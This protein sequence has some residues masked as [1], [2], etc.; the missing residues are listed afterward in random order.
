MGREATRSSHVVQRRYFPQQI[1]VEPV[2]DVL[3]PLYPVDRLAGAR[4]LVRLAGEA[5]LHGGLVQVLEGTE[6]RL[7]AL[8][9]WCP[10]VCI[11]QD[12]HQGR[13]D[14]VRVAHG[15]AGEVLLRIAERSGAE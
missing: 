11:S 10:E 3:Q 4:Q 12:E 6:H 15:R 5:H 9:G 8:G 1:L 14:T 13:G 7:T 2:E